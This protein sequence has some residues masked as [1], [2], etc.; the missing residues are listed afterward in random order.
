M[1]MPSLRGLSVAVE[2]HS[3][4]AGTEGSRRPTIAPPARGWRPGGGCDRGRG[5]AQELRA[6]LLTVV[7]QIPGLTVSS[8]ETRVLQFGFWPSYNVPF[9]PEV[10]PPL[11]P[12]PPTLAPR[13]HPG[14]QPALKSAYTAASCRACS[15]F[16]LGKP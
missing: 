13:P 1:R 4:S 3:S 7:E 16:R 6:G 12:A 15:S 5:G 8:D 2:M 10:P 11:P 9:F 14:R